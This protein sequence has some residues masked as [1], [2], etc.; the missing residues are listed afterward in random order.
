VA[1]RRYAR[2]ATCT[3]LFL[4]PAQRPSPAD[5]ARRYARHENAPDDA[6]YRA[7]L[8]RLCAPLAARLRPGAAGL[9]FGCGPSPVLGAMLTAAGFPT[10]SYDPL[11]HPDASL[12]ERR[13][14]FVACC[15]VLEHVHQPAATLDR[16]ARLL[17][18]GGVL[19]VMT[20]FYGVEQPFEQ[21]WYRRDPTH[22][23]FYAEST[24]RWMAAR[25]GWSL[26]VPAPH[27]ALFDVPAPG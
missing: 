7:F 6:G 1:G 12:L 19:G 8:D 26:S 24:M 23:C 9:D 3:L 18:G 15:E 21:W 5:E 11:F 22:V 10:E 25:R 20:R 2:C 16:F 14:D 13:Y 17:G 27:V 4:D